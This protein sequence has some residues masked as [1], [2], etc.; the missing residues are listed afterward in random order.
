M[1]LTAVELCGPLF[2]VCPG[3][4]QTR[5][6]RDGKT[7][8]RFKMT[9]TC[10]TLDE[11]SA[12]LLLLRCPQDFIY[13][14]FD[15]NYLGKLQVCLATAERMTLSQIRKLRNDVDRIHCVVTVF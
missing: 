9:K 4:E 15:I 14:D 3:D 13:E 1:E 7:R 5:I 10:R 11:A 8:G 6:R 2:S 12:P